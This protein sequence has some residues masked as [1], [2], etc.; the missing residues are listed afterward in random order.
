MRAQPGTESIRNTVVFEAF[1][2]LFLGHEHGAATD[3]TL[4]M[5]QAMQGVH[6]AIVAG[7][8]LAVAFPGGQ[9]G[10]SLTLGRTLRLIGSRHD[11]E[12][13]VASDCLRGLALARLLK[14]GAIRPVPSDAEQGVA[15]TRARPD[16]FL[17]GTWD[18]MD[19]RSRAR[20]K[21]GRCLMDE[22]DLLARREQLA[23]RGRLMKRL[24]SV[25]LSSAT[26]NRRYPIYVGAAFRS[27]NPGCF[28][29]Y[30]LSDGTGSVPVF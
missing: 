8:K 9:S 16:K 21:A 13:A 20:R 23:E 25:M 22:D 1:V 17:P 29:S 19:R 11:V 26:T 5:N 4:V 28:T 18:R 3:V 30:G 12:A 27:P 14:V 7:C 6:A 2:D 10:D 15:Y 24:P